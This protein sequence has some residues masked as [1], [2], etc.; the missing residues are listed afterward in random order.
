MTT[1]V[2]DA[3]SDAQHSLSTIRWVSLVVGVLGFLA[4]VVG[5]VL[6]R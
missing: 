1:W 4:V 3:F 6:S 2:K 5:L